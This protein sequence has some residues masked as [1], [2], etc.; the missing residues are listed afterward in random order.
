MA[1]QPT[2][3]ESGDDAPPATEPIELSEV[4]QLAAEMGWKPE[5]DYTGSKERWK[6][7]K[8]FLKT[9]REISRGLRETV[10]GLRD[11]VDRV[12]SASAKQTERALKEQAREINERF[13]E[14]VENKDAA[15]AAAA[16]KEMRELEASAAPVDPKNLEADFASRNPWYGSNKKATAYAVMT[17]NELA[18]KGVPLDKQL[19]Q[20]EREMRTEFPELFGEEARGTKAPPGVH[21]PTSRGVTGKK[22]KGFADLPPEAK[23]AAE[24]YA[25][26]FKDRHG[27]EPEESKASYAKDYWSNAGES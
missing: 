9:E 24:D 15:G 20:V 8:D 6:P 11:T 22:A 2:E 1:T 7:A 19:E 18:A 16:A 25:K 4:E 21:A 26:L 13:A 14:A 17:S 3:I 12:A 10:K 27:K 23:R 5:G